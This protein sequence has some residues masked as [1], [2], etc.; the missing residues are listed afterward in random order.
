MRQAMLLVALGLAVGCGKKPADEPA[1]SGQGPAPGT[2]ATPPKKADDGSVGFERLMTEYGENP[3]A[4]DAKYKGKQVVVTGVT[5]EK[6][7]QELKDNKP[8]VV[9]AARA[10][11]AEKGRCLWGFHEAADRS[12]AAA[13][14]GGGYTV[15]G[16][17]NG[18]ADLATTRLFVDP[19]AADWFVLF[20]RSTVRTP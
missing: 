3:V 14:P 6:I 20:K 5:I 16:T 4:A 18:R 1:G 10:V 12:V 15:E 11:G 2:P 17:C 7:G 9:S 8:F 13:R 19:P